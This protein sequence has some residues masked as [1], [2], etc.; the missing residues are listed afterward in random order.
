MSQ[1]YPKISIITPNY[2]LGDYIEETILSVIN[3]NYPN[4]EYII[5]DGGSND[6]SIDIIKKYQDKITYFSS[7]K[8]AGMYSA[9][10][11]GFELSTGEIMAW[12]NSDDAYINRSLF[13][14][15]EIFN[16]FPAIEW[17]V[18][19]S[20]GLDELG[21][22]TQSEPPKM[23]SKYNFYLHNYKW[24]Q[25]ESTFWRRSL[26]DKTGSKL[27]TT[28]Q[29]AGDFELWLRF[30]RSAKLYSVQAPLGSYRL[31]SKNQKS[32]ENIAGYIRECEILLNNYVLNK[33]EKAF[34]K[35]INLFRLLLK[36]PIL[37]SIPSIKEKYR[38]FFE[39]PGLLKFD[40]KTQ[41]YML[42]ET[43]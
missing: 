16:S 32:V 23:W 29:L 14:V 8:D 6:N 3:Q 42:H 25:Q 1:E 11:K 27:N 22:M 21:R 34:I 31:R 4:V 19:C 41:R 30:F 39:Y 38:S 37:M 18:G 35:K 7:E 12:I 10:Q 28:L 17:I 36:I 13:T 5:I 9:V 2:N 26:W 24:I 43:L 40:R 33:E 15:A 20:T